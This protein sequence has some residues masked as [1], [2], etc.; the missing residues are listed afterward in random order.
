LGVTAPGPAAR[1]VVLLGASKGIGR[2]VARQM[3]ARGDALFLLG[4]DLEDL[5][6]SARDL[7]VRAGQPAGSIGTAACDLERPE[8]FAA[9]LEAASAALGGF[10]TVVVTA[11]LF[12]SQSRLED[13]PEFA[14]RLLTADFANTVV[15]CEEARRRLLARGGGTLCVFSSVAG[16]RGRKP[17]ILYGA[18][19]AGLTRYLEG[20]DHKFR[21]Q[22]LRTICVKPGFVRTGM[23]EGLKPPPF[24]GE[25]EDVAAIAVRAIDRGKPIVYA[26][27]IWALIMF[28]IRMLPRFVMRKIGF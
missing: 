21:A 5:G 23:T 3:A 26:P 20:L 10:D 6:R 22:G 9:A 17:V 13:D 15:F 27:G 7:E 2:A 14:R 18:A 25:P 1:K 8:G 19:K 4:R 24:A 28:V 12:A 11:G 16:E